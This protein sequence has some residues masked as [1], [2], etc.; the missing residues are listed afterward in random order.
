MKFDNIDYDL[1]GM[2]FEADLNIIATVVNLVPK[3]G[4]ILEIGAHLGRTSHAI[5]SVKDSSVKL[6]IIDPWGDKIPVKH[7]GYDGSDSNWEIASKIA[8]ETNEIKNAFD[9][10]MNNKQGEYTAIVDNS[11]TYKFD[12]NYDFVFIDGDHSF[13]AVTSDINNFISNENTIIGGDDY[14]DLY[15]DDV[16]RAVDSFS[17][18]RTLL[19]P[20]IPHSKLWFL[21]PKTGYWPSVVSVIHEAIAS[22]SYSENKNENIT[23]KKLF[24]NVLGFLSLGMAYIGIVTP[25]IPFSIFLVGAAYSFARGSKRM[26]AWLYNHKHFG[27]F[28]TNWGQKRVFPQRGKYAMIMVMSI[29]LISMMFFVPLPGVLFSG[30]FML[31]VAIWAWRYPG[32]VEE[33]Q[34]RKDNNEKIGWF[35]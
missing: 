10:F 27:P 25:G 20:N 33:W 12:E 1:P 11:L 34:R 7:D 29:S 2:M 21:V 24:W 28:L 16:V 9:F 18:R 26:E 5:C 35:K 4:H 6:S 19:I 8:I 14:G 32:S 30:I 31:L 22:Q 3:N 13:D 17:D 23:M 15:Q